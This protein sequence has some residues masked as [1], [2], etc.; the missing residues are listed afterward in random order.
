MGFRVC[1]L[2]FGVLV[3]RAIG[4]IRF[5]VQGW[6]LR[7]RGVGFWELR[8]LAFDFGFK[9]LGRGCR[10]TG[11][12][13]RIVVDLGFGVSGVMLRCLGF[14]VWDLGLWPLDSGCVIILW[15]RCL[16]NT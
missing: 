8:A 15:V 4:F 2:G 13:L 3:F 7:V 5:R 9:S 10:S 11:L 16:E 6:G 1:G 12:G 14:Q